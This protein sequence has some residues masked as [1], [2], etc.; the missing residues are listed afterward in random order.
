M[1]HVQAV[2][3]LHAKLDLLSQTEDVILT[4]LVIHTAISVQLALKGLAVALVLLVPPTAPAAQVESA[5][6]A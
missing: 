4:F 6:N 3:V 5:Y 2:F 1:Q